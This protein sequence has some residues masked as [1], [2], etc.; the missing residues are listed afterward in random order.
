MVSAVEKTCIDSDNG[1][2]YFVNGKVEALIEQGVWGNWTDFCVTGSEEGNLVE[3]FCNPDGT[4]ESV[5]YQCPNIC[6]NGSCIDDIT[7]LDMTCADSDGGKN[8][9]QKGYNHG[10][11][12]GENVL[13]KWEDYCGSEQGIK[14]LYEYYCN[15]EGL[16]EEEFY[17]C[18]SSCQYGYCV[19][20]IKTETI[21]CVFEESEDV[22]SCFT[23]F[24]NGYIDSPQYFCQ[25]VNSCEVT[26][27]GE[28]GGMLKWV[29]GS[30]FCS[31]KSTT[32]IDGKNKTIKFNCKKPPIWKRTFKYLASGYDL[33]SALSLETF[34]K[35]RIGYRDFDYIC[36]DGSEAAENNDAPICKNHLEWSES[37]D[38]FCKEKCNK[39][40]ICGT[41]TAH[42]NDMCLL[43]NPSEDF[44]GDLRNKV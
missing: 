18:P 38:T 23:Y 25:D 14:G 32:I 22:N 24:E 10:I 27:I 42:F 2:N 4:A 5:I 39:E 17:N 8:Y 12:K 6:F 33:I 20:Q 37:I 16:I 3:Q 29:A 30:D 26:I 19:N 36:S 28:E 9:Y 15:L 35:D 34:Y 11:F 40:G 43:D 1:R 21:T 41:D 13:G 7:L 31:G 44:L